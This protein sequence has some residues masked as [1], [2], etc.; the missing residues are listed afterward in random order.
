MTIRDSNGMFARI[1]GKLAKMT[2]V[3]EGFERTLRHQ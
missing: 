3:N 1:S 2:K